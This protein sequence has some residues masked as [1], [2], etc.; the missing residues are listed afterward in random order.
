MK[1]YFDPGIPLLKFYPNKIT[2]FT[3][4]HLHTVLYNTKKKKKQP[5]NNI[6]VPQQ[7]TGYINNTFIRSNTV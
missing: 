6:Y 5:R 7:E 1:I 4:I 2:I 3:K